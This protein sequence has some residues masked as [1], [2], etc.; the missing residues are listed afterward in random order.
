MEHLLPSGPDSFGAREVNA[1]GYLDAALHDAGVD[2][3]DPPVALKGS[4]LLDEQAHRIHAQR[5]ADLSEAERESVLRSA[6]K[7]NFGSR[8]VRLLLRYGL[9]AY[10]GDPVHGGNPAGKVWAQLGHR[11]GYPRPT[12]KGI[13]H[14]PEKS[15]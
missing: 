13:A 6:V 10:L 9:E 7:K 4:A 15:S 5:F 14:I 12:Q 8:L 2:P 11:P 3:E 1:I